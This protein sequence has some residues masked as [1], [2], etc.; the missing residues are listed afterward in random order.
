MTLSCTVRATT[1]RLVIRLA[2]RPSGSSLSA[3]CEIPTL[4]KD[5]NHHLYKLHGSIFNP[6]PDRYGLAR[7]PAAEGRMKTDLEGGGEGNP[8]GLSWVLPPTLM[9]NR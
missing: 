7:P 1:L 8:S 3:Q 4:Q 5:P 9:A 2:K 6:G